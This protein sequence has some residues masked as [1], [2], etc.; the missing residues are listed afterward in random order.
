MRQYIV[1]V[2]CLGRLDESLLCGMVA[3]GAETVYL[4]DGSL[5]H[6]PSHNRS[7]DSISCL[8]NRQFPDA[9]VRA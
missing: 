5:R 6:L 1:E 3:N 4:V 8:Q 7:Y 2:T 9:D